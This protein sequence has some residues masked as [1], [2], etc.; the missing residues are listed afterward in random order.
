GGGFERR[1]RDDRRSSSG[2]GFERRDRDERR[3]SSG[4]GFERSEEK[5]HKFDT[6]PQHDSK[7]GVFKQFKKRRTPSF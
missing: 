6:Q 2:G 5:K 3:S 1:D 7:F 4:G